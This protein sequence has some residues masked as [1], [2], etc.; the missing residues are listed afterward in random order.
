MG[1]VWVAVIVTVRAVAVGKFGGGL[2]TRV[3]EPCAAGFVGVALGFA[4]LETLGFAPLETLGFAPLETLGFVAPDEFGF[5]LP[6]TVGLGD[7]VAGGFVAL[8]VLGLAVL[9]FILLEAVGFVALGLFVLGFGL[10]DTVGFVAL[11][12]LGF[13]AGLLAL[14]GFWLLWLGFATDRRSVSPTRMASEVR[15]LAARKVARLMLLR[16]AIF[17]SVSP[18]CTTTVLFEVGWLV[19]LAATVAGTFSDCPTRMLLLSKAFKACSTS[20][21]VL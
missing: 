21:L 10:L 7:V 11:E 18:G 5:A 15:L 9:G 2:I 16:L 6:E 14:L 3:V 12:A 8:E 1:R 17:S 4:P 19:G 13:G 20:T